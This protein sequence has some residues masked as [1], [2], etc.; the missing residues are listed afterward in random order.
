MSYRQRKAIPDLGVG[1]G[2]RSP[3]LA[4]VV[5][6][7]PP[8]DWFEIVSENYLAE[9]GIQR[10][11]LEQVRAAYPVVPHGVSLGIGGADDLDA[12]YLSRLKALV[13]RVGAPWCSD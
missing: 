3:H 4:D 6:A 13:R 11:Q 1:V 5:R 9:G 12:A 10:R 8:M 2:L 7:R